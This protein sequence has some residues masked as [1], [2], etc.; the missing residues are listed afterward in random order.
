MINGEVM[1]EC[2]STMSARLEGWA[3]P[4]GGVR[5]SNQHTPIP[6]V[7]FATA[8]RFKADDDNRKER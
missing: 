3:T 5:G 8:S 1:G 7:Y 6:A 2:S 4:M